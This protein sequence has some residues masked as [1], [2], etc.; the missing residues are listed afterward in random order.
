MS[1]PNLNAP[2]DRA[3]AAA[4][5]Q[6]MVA[7]VHTNEAATELLEHLLHRIPGPDA[8]RRSD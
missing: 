8:A 5:T 7:G 4:L 6:S 2:F 1:E 3:A